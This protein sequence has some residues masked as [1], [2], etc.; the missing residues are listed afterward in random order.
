MDK[1]TQRTRIGRFDPC[2]VTR[3]IAEENIVTGDTALISVTVTDRFISLTINGK[4][5]ENL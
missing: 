4:I 5:Q 3:D 2:Y 1:D